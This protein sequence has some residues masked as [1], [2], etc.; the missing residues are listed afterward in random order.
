M[1]I[2]E[3]IDTSKREMREY[4][5]DKSV[6]EESLMKCRNDLYM[7]VMK[8]ILTDTEIRDMRWAPSF[9]ALQL[10]SVD[11]SSKVIDTMFKLYHNDIR[12]IFFT[13]DQFKDT[14]RIV[15]VEFYPHNMV[16]TFIDIESM[17]SFILERNIQLSV[18]DISI[19]TQI[20][21]LE[22]DMVKMHEELARIGSRIRIL[23]E[24][25]SMQEGIGS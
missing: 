4:V 21:S 8:W 5:N 9:R 15:S 10:S 20:T 12:S 13:P 24:L 3:T 2:S 23:K 17:V 6:A 16:L 25:K 1:N 11:A 14:E 19:D 22:K 7:A 18:P